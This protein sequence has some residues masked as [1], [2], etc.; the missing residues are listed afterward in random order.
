MSQ[1]DQI[2][3]ISS[4]F[5]IIMLVGAMLTKKHITIKLLR[6]TIYWFFIIILIVFIYSFR[7]PVKDGFRRIY[8]E[9][10]PAEAMQE[11][12]N[13]TIRKS[14]DGQFYV[15]ALVNGQSIRFLIDTGATQVVLNKS[16]AINAGINFN[17]L[18]FNMIAT[19]ANGIV[20]LASTTMN[21]SIGSFTLNEFNVSI[22]ESELGISL[23][24]M[25]FLNQF[26]EFK[27]EGDVLYLKY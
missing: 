1:T 10:V 17:E 25:S 11:G 13:L 19:T 14:I 2:Q 15:N 8:A 20:K 4:I 24:G 6:Y 5:I 3:A 22:A 26:H 7:D 12:K 9:L 21:I 16:D 18:K 23:L 27:F